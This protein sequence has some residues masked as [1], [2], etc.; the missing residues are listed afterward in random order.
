MKLFAIAA[1]LAVS[2]AGCSPEEARTET[3]GTNILELEVQGLAFVGPDTVKSGWTTIRVVNKGGMTHHAL[4]YRLPDGITAQ[5]V[6]EQVVVPIQKSL[7][8]AIAGDTQKA[9]EIAATMPAW[10]GD[11]TWLGG[12]GMMSDGVTGEA[13]MYLEPGNYIVECYVKTNGVQHNYNPEPGELGM[14]F[15]LTVL[16]EDGGMAEPDANVT[17]T[18]SNNGYEITDGAFVAGE[19]SVRAVFAEQRL[20][21]D[22]VGH[23]AHVF[24]IAEDTDIDAAASWPDFFP[25][26]GQQTPAPASF[27]GGIHDMPQGAT[28]YFKLTLEPGDYGITAEIPDARQSGFFKRFGVGAN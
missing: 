19:N 12:P 27:V 10:V 16:A 14:V 2:L 26:D 24:R 25:V 6:D 4:V 21:N 15:P 13:T 17:L 28:G 11:L 1:V 7:T 5:M 8:A 22:F 20:Y 3:P 9:A 23:D 18:L